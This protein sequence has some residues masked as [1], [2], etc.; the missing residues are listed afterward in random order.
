VSVSLASKVF[1]I[2]LTILLAAI[3]NGW[4]REVA[5]IPALGPVWGLSASG[6]LLSLIILAVAYLFL[7]WLNVHG[8]VRL[9][10]LGG[11]WLALT[12]IFEFSFGLLSGKA[13]F[14]VLAAYSFQGGNLWPL[15]LLVTALSP[16]V[17]AKLRRWG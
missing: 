11:V 6:L 2:W 5:L 7:P 4:L 15:V 9:L 10:Q 17:A 16:W 8:Q 3:A 12:L 1:I 14:E 13:L